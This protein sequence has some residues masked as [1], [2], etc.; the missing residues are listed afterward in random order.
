MTPITMGF[1][2]TSMF[3]I[4]INPFAL[5]YPPVLKPDA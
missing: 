5:R 1:L 2:R 4:V 3:D